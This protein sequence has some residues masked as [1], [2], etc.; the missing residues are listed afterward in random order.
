MA[1][2][3]LRLLKPNLALFVLAAGCA[4]IAWNVT[5]GLPNTFGAR[6][7]LNIWFPLQTNGS[8][9]SSNAGSSS[10]SRL[11][12]KRFL[13]LPNGT[14]AA[15]TANS[16]SN[17]SGSSHIS[18][19]KVL[20]TEPGPNGT[21]VEVVAVQQLEAILV[22]NYRRFFSSINAKDDYSF[23]NTP[24]VP[25]S[26]SSGGGTAKPIVRRV[27]EPNPHI[28]AYISDKLSWG[29]PPVAQPNVSTSSLMSA[30]DLFWQCCTGPSLC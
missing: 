18:S 15:A 14:A 26:N 16:S 12:T 20:V 5:T 3:L 2:W 13:L 28:P 24:L 30:A 8:D 19:G 21:V 4:G 23:L 29:S 17:S 1:P 10:G 6:F 25:G 27:R 11:V 7:V 22:L 9:S